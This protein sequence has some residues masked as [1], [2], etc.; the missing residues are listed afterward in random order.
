M[1]KKVLIGALIMVLGVGS[2]IGYAETTQSPNILPRFRDNTTINLEERDAW[3]KER[4]DY[5]NEQIEKALESGIITEEEAR[6]WSEHF[7]YMDDFQSKNSFGFGFGGCGG[8]GG[9]RGMGMMRGHGFRGGFY[10]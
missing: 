5:R 6:T 1:K 10:R 7:S 3:L 9:A 8:F 4:S 2:I